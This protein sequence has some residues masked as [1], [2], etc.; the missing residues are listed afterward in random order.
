M[1]PGAQLRLLLP[2]LKITD[3]RGLRGLDRRVPSVGGNLNHGKEAADWISEI[4][5]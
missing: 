2:A 4:G 3:F 1:I 5:W